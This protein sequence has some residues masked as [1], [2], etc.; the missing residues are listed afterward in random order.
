MSG[1]GDVRAVRL[2]VWLYRRL[3]RLLPTGLR[4]EYGA[5]LLADFRLLVRRAHERAGAVGAAAAA[6]RG[7]GDIVIRAPVDRKS[8]V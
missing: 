6:V 2:A 1:Q 4:E 5:A 8:V 3:M 7:C